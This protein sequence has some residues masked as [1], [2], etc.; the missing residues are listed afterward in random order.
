MKKFFAIAI[1]IIFF[2]T[3]AVSAETKTE[4]IHSFIKLSRQ[5]V[6]EIN[7]TK[8]IKISVESFKT[9]AGDGPEFYQA[10]FL[11]YTLDKSGNWVELDCGPIFTHQLVLGSGS[12]ST[13]N[14]QGIV[15][16]IKTIIAKE[17]NGLAA[18]IVFKIPDFETWINT[19][20]P[21]TYADLKDKQKALF[22]VIGKDPR[23]DGS[24][25]AIVGEEIKFKIEMNPVVIG[26]VVVA[27]PGQAEPVIT[28]EFSSEGLWGFSSLGFAEFSYL[29]DKD[30]KYLFGKEGKYL[31]SYYD[32]SGRIPLAE[33]ELALMVKTPPVKSKTVTETPRKVQPKRTASSG[34]S[35]E[36]KNEFMELQVSPKP[37]DISNP[38]ELQVIF[39]PLIENVEQYTVELW[40]G[41]PTSVKIERARSVE[42]RYIQLASG[43]TLKTGEAVPVR[44]DK[45]TSGKTIGLQ[46]AINALEGVDLTGT[47]KDTWWIRVE[48]KQKGAADW[49]DNEILIAGENVQEAKP[50]P[51]DC[52]TVWQ[53]LARIDKDR[54]IAGVFK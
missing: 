5:G 53:C 44:I 27:I 18:F 54:F 24:F 52:K 43:R 48:L 41:T 7:L 3:I 10:T 22:S 35:A 6:K 4:E 14:N 49:K 37:I 11:L 39:T 9:R 50:K 40:R 8:D 19:T 15:M 30:G 2:A 1:L 45:I 26:K 51:F 25:E 29:P 46:N 13:C 42:L 16:T 23:A 28:D 47:D 31:F 12:Q 33:Q 34:T 20:Q 32:Y 21:V 17:E 38:S 36:T